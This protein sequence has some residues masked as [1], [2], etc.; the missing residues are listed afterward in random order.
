[1]E[2][3]AR[4]RAMS[5]DA[6]NG[7][8]VFR[9]KKSKKSVL[10]IVDDLMNL[11]NRL[12]AAEILDSQIVIY[13]AALAVKQST[14][15]GIGYDRAYNEIIKDYEKIRLKEWISGQMDAI[16]KYYLEAKL[17]GSLN[18]FEATCLNLLNEHNLIIDS[19]LKTLDEIEIDHKTKDTILDDALQIY[20]EFKFNSKTKIHF[21]KEKKESL[22]AFYSIISGFQLNT[23]ER[24][25]STSET[26]VARLVLSKAS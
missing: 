22:V 4:P 17:L 19:R 18:G 20:N 25:S 26:K 16:T 10:S 12:K 3:I 15:K 23:V 7:V 1:M 8:I 21:A 6:L 13:L 5:Y 9:L 11:K 24:R 14:L 2:R